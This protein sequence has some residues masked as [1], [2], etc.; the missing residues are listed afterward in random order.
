MPPRDVLSAL[1]R[2]ATP[3]LSLGIVIAAVVIALE[4]LVIILLQH[5][6]PGETFEP[7]YLLGILVVSM[8]WG[9][10][11]AV[12]TSLVSAI[13]LAYFGGARSGDEFAPFNFQNGVLVVVFLVAAL[14]TNFIAGLARVRAVEAEQRRHEAEDAKAGLRESRDRI[15]VLAEQQAALRR[16]ATLVARGAPGFEVFATVAEQLARALGA[17]NAS[18]WRYESDG[19]ATLVSAYDDPTQETAMPIGT[20]WS[21]EGDNVVGM[22]L[23]S[24]RPA[25]IDTGDSLGSAAARIRELGLRGGVGAP[26]AVEGNLWGAAVV[27]SVEPGP[28]PADT[29][30][31]VAD[32]AD[33][34]ATAIANAESRAELTASRIR[35]V[36]AGDEARRRLERDLH[37]GAQQ[38]LVSLALELRTLQDSVP[39]EFG[40]LSG[41]IARVASGL[42][43]ASENLQ[44]LSRGI[45]PAIL[46]KGGLVPALKTLARRCPVPVDLDIAVE[47]RLPDSVEIGAYYAVAEAL[48]NAA[49]YA[50]ASEVSVRA[51]LQGDS[52]CLTISDDGIGGAD[53]RKGSGLIGL[54]DRIEVLGGHVLVSSPTG[55]GTALY[56]TIP[57]AVQDSARLT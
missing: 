52:L 29:E 4:T 7:V 44:E 6:S 12:A 28:L 48:T 50:R 36:A 17:A 54:K 8:V 3:P 18:L 25:R 41:Q 35:I 43:A 32:F 39:S 14:C 21:L 15:S 40:A 31:R 22:I 9:L 23:A 56:I 27:G 42:T 24:G 11:L 53:S 38:R 47:R 26:I 55:I 49:K 2:P 20:R 46:S 16:V 37:D 13:A 45:H 57:K 5:L 30:A 10:G 33:L 19:T 1:L 34:V 51:V